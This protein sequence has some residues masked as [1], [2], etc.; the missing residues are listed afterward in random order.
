MATVWGCHTGTLPDPNNVA[1]AG[2]ESA[3]VIQRQL[4]AAADSLNVRRAHREI[5][6]RQYSALISKIA[7]DYI[8]QAKDVKITNANARAWGRVFVTAKDWEKAESAVRQG[9]DAESV[10]AKQ[11][12]RALG[13]WIYDTLTLA[14]VEAH[15]KKVPEAVK[16]ARSVFEVPGKAKA[17]ILTS[18][19]YEIVPAAQGQGHDLEL[20]DL[21]RDAIQQH[22][23]TIVD[24]NSDGGRDFLIAR[25]HHIR[26][27]WEQ[28]ALLYDS[29][30][31]DDEAAKC[32]AE[33]RKIEQETIRL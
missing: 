16:L 11:D 2:P 24:P 14:R 29:A 12:Y 20:A 31:K 6:D 22:E 26:R 30:G 8:A 9:I 27:A 28:A 1:K 17:P 4:D 23:E 21:I 15:L 7:H 3:E 10:R 18:V 13:D 33:A 25:P 5:N 19:V 32:I